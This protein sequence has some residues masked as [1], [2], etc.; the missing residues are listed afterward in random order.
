MMT[1]LTLTQIDELKA[2]VALANA[3]VNALCHGSR[4]WTM[5][6]PAEPDR[7]SDLVIGRALDGVSTLV[8]YA[9]ERAAREA[10]VGPQPG[11][12]SLTEHSAEVGSQW[13]A[14]W[15]VPFHITASSGFQ[16]TP[17]AAYLALTEALKGR[18]L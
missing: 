17:T 12:V 14:D 16:P 2:Q 11:L 9:K 8:E 15:L 7:D 4:R 18:A 5:T 3:E 6:V 10:C 13:E 1:T